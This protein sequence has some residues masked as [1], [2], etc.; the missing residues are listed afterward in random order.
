MGRKDWHFFAESGKDFNLFKIPPQ[1]ADS[2]KM[3]VS[4]KS[5][6]SFFVFFCH[7]R[8]GGNDRFFTSSSKM[9]VR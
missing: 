2:L 8:E 5:V 1:K 9:K 7:S 3:I 4:Q 6:L